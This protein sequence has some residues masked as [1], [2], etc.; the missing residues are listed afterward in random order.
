[1]RVMS[2]VC[3]YWS[4]NSP[5]NG[6]NFVLQLKRLLVLWEQPRGELAFRTLL[7]DASEM[8]KAPKYL[9][10]EIQKW[11]LNGK[12]EFLTRP[13][14]QQAICKTASQDLMSKASN[15]QGW[16]I[17]CMN[18]ISSRM[19]KLIILKGR[20]SNWQKIKVQIFEYDSPSLQED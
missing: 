7:F 15:I 1:M 2:L 4:I 18:R 19:W 3:P 11:G 9:G 14:Y 16:M 13:P 6:L 5:G 17:W 20:I 8:I 10:F 12:A